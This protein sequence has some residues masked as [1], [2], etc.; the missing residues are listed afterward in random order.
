MDR[1]EAKSRAEEIFH[2]V[3]LDGKENE[4]LKFFSQG[5]K[6]RFMIALSL[7]NDPRNLVLDEPQKRL[8]STRECNG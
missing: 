4:K 7:I 6:R 5:M 3:G 8:R 2:L 1:R